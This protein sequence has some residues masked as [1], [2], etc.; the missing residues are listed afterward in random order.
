VCLAG[1]EINLS[2]I[3][4]LYSDSCD[5][6]LWVDFLS[7]DDFLKVAHVVRAQFPRVHV[8]PAPRALWG[9]GS[10]AQ[11]MIA[12]LAYALDHLP[13]WQ[14]CLF[15]SVVD[16]PL[17]A[18]PILLDKCRT[19]E[20]FDFCSSKWAMY[21]PGELNCDYKVRTL[22]ERDYSPEFDQYKFRPN[23]HF[24]I[25]SQLRDVIPPELIKVGR[26]TRTVEDRYRVSVI[27]NMFQ[28]N[29]IVRLLSPE[30]AAERRAFFKVF[31]LVFG[32]NWFLASRR[33][34]KILT[35]DRVLEIYNDGFRDVLNPDESFFHSAAEYFRGR[36]K[37]SI[38]W[39]CLQY[40]HGH[41]G[42]FGSEQYLEIIRL[43]KN[44]ELF[45]RK[46]TEVM[47]YADLIESVKFICG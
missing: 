30:R 40:N 13:S 23:T 22:H 5:M 4:F 19:F 32:R 26:P 45:A 21:A 35:S 3:R 25:D 9:G 15:T 37:I 34:A 8:R 10:V 28:S 41:P 31:P 46:A 1:S 18:L 17:M 24:V 42:R 43:A 44:N 38:S 2:L 29:L 16:A 12:A 11:S 36:D 27:E 33:F 6:L 14:L 20:F 39:Q 47:D 7:L